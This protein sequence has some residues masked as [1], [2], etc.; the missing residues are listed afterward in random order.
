MQNVLAQGQAVHTN[1][2]AVTSW[3]ST[4]GVVFN[5]IS[6]LH[7]R[8]WRDWQSLMPAVR[9]LDVDSQVLYCLHSTWCLS[10]RRGWIAIWQHKWRRFWWQKC[11]KI[12]KQT[13]R[14]LKK[15]THFL[16]EFLSI[17]MNGKLKRCITFTYWA[18]EEQRSN[19]VKYIHNIKLHS[20]WVFIPRSWMYCIWCI[21]SNITSPLCLK[22]PCAKLYLE[23]LTYF[24]MDISPFPVNRHFILTMVMGSVWSNLSNHQERED[25]ASPARFASVIRDQCCGLKLDKKFREWSVFGW[26]VVLLELSL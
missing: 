10:L 12:P 2:A 13:L 6:C 25:M 19:T 4:L 7:T 17:R 5:L 16:F 11:T 9:I 23:Q 20:S 1:T 24:C 14:D 18:H 15:K 8:L 22:L 21:M 26:A 3:T